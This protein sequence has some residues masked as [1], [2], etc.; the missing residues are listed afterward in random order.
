MDKHPASSSCRVTTL[1][2]RVLQPNKALFVHSSDLIS[3]Q[4]W[5]SASFLSQFPFLYQCL[6]ELPFKQT[7]CIPICVPWSASEETQKR[8]T[9]PV[10]QVFCCF[11]HC[12][13]GWRSKKAEMQ[14]KH[15]FIQHSSFSKYILS[16]DLM[17]STVLG[18]A[19][20]LISSGSEELSFTHIPVHTPRP[21]LSGL[22]VGVVPGEASCEGDG[23][24]KVGG[25]LL[26]WSS[27]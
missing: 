3:Q 9:F 15:S 22:E 12:E 1:T 11:G 24:S 27:G 7:A 23:G 14:T 20:N 18:P 25:E 21:A 10:G 4:L 8:T 5:V 16:I 6:S 26:R 19:G 17:P 2:P 13:R